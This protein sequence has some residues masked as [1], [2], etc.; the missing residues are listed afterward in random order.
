[1]ILLDINPL[2]KPVAISEILIL[3]IIAAIVGFLVARWITNRKI[4]SL[5][6]TLSA[7]LDDLDDCRSKTR[8]LANLGILSMARK[9]VHTSAQPV[10]RDNLKIIEGIGPKLEDLLNQNGILT[11]DQLAK[12]GP[13]RIAEILQHAGSRFQMHDP[14]TWMQQS[15]LARDGKWD[16][17]NELQDK[18]DGGRTV[19]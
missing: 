15:S 1:M 14:A 11:F 18:L 10:V 13:I 12:T 2:S 5:K 3:M 17:L 7:R 8:N 19:S 4:S 9:E 16:E 6:E